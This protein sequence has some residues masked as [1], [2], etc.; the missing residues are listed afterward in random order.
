M[1]SAK[2]R[3]FQPYEKEKL[4][5][6]VGN[7]PT[8][9]PIEGVADGYWKI[10][11]YRPLIDIKYIAALFNREPKTIMNELIRGAYLEISKSIKNQSK[12]YCYSQ[13]ASNSYH[14]K[15]FSNKKQ[16]QLKI[17]RHR[18]ILEFVLANKGKQSLNSIA[19]RTRVD[20][21]VYTISHQT[22]YNYV[23]NPKM[24]EINR[25]WLSRTKKHHYRLR[26]KG[27]R[28]NGIS[29]DERP[30]SINSREEFG[31]WEIDLVEGKRGTSV[32]L[33]TLT[34]RKTRLG[35]A[36]K[37][38]NKKAKTIVKALRM[39]QE[40]YVLEFGHNIKSITTDNGVE[41]WGWQEFQKSIYNACKSISVYFCH[42][43]CACDKGSVENFNKQIRR[44]YPKGTDFTRINDFEIYQTVTWINNIWRPILGYKSALEIYNKCYQ[45]NFLGSLLLN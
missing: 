34:E 7:E 5:K 23:D 39:L 32:N 42:P 2:Y 18:E 25:S 14:N 15:V 31:H 44:K 30:L 3:W 29:I 35:I 37:I 6:L 38:N 13:D 24:I 19:H 21:M 12:L 17:Y 43:Y 45:P 26:S 40:K 9:E 36:I 22:L 4:M 8:L 27:K 1:N 10:L 28:V 41:F 16:S 20:N 33:L 11:A